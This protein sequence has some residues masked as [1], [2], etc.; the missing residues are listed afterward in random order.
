MREKTTGLKLRERAATAA[1]A[2]IAMYFFFMILDRVLSLVYGSNFQPYG[3]SVPPG[4]TI[5]GHMFNGSMALLGVWAWLKLWELGGRIKYKWVLRVAVTL[6]ALV[7]MLWIPYNNDADY[8][9]RLGH[10]NT[11]PLYMVVNAAYVWGAGIVTLKQFTTTKRRIILLLCLFAA[12]LFV[13]F[14][15]YAPRF[16]EFRWT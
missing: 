3:P 9:V 14:V 2:V 16:P 6:V 5:W 11:I 13:H 15:L 7:P 8:L 12:F 4:F 1:Y 10:G